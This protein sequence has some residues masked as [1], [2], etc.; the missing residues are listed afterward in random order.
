MSRSKNS[1]DIR[2]REKGVK[3][4]KRIV[5][6]GEP[7]MLVGPESNK[8]LYSMQDMAE[9]LYGEGYRCIVLPPAGVKAV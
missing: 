4:G 8:D 6:D 3:V 9:D 1:N 7:Q 2:T 5:K